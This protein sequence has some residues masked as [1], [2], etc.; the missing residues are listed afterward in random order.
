MGSLSASELI[1][2]LKIVK[3]MNKAKKKKKNKSR[4]KKNKK[5]INNGSGGGGSDDR[6]PTSTYLQSPNLNSQIQ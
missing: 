2:I 4:K 6:V 5:T 1:K 3:D